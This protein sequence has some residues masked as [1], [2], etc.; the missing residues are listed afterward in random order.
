M[1]VSGISATFPN[2]RNCL[3]TSWSAS[4]RAE[5]MSR[6]LSLDTLEIIGGGIPHVVLKQET[7]DEL[8]KEYSALFRRSVPELCSSLDATHAS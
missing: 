3:A 4:G 5:A 1:L 2:K 6:A 8:I 7:W